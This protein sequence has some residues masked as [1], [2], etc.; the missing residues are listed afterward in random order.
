[1]NSLNNN[2]KTY[3]FSLKLSLFRETSELNHIALYQGKANLIGL[4][5]QCLLGI[6]HDNDPFYST[7]NLLKR[8]FCTE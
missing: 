6:I 4:N 8:D 7:L 1:M 2:L 5:S 3:G